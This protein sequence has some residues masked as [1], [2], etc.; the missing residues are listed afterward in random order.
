MGSH[1]AAEELKAIETT[2]GMASSTEAPILKPIGIT[3]DDADV[4]LM[5]LDKIST[6]YEINNAIN[7]TLIL[8]S[9]KRLTNHFANPVFSIA[10]PSDSPPAFNIRTSQLRFLISLVLNIPLTEK[11][12]IAIKDTAAVGIP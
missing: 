11:I 5:K 9:G 12:V 10:T 1:I 7:I 4:L 3:M 8:S 2:T 6:E